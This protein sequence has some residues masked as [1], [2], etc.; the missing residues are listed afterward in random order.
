MERGHAP[1]AP[2]TVLAPA[3]P[4]AGHF[5]GLD[6]TGALRLRTRTGMETITAGDVNP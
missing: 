2:M 6:D 4:V 1:D 3:G 5:A